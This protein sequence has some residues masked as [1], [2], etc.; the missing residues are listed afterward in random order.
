MPY[1]CICDSSVQFSL[2]YVFYTP[3]TWDLHPGMFGHIGIAWALLFNFL[4]AFTETCEDDFTLRYGRIGK[5]DN[6][7]PPIKHLSSYKK[8][9]T[10]QSLN[11]RWKKESDSTRQECS[12]DR[13][14]ISEVCTYA[15]MVRM[16]MIKFSFFDM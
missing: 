5:D 11:E 14:T 4:K 1:C 6:D 7:S 2:T 15:W 3:G 13:E 16:P 8:N 12:N 10:V 9:E